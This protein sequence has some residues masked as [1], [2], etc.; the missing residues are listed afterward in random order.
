M[1]LMLYGCMCCRFLDHL[2]DG[3]WFVSVSFVVRGL[4]G[5]GASACLT[6]SFAILAYTFPT[7]VVTMFVCLNI[8][9]VTCSMI[10]NATSVS[11]T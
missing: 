6:A 10:F 5:I 7:N 11:V 3:A 4:A 2:P 1:V 9:K 8:Y